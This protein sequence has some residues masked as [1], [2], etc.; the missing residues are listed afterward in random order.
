M[1]RRF[2]GTTY[3]WR[4]IVIYGVFYVILHFIFHMSSYFPGKNPYFV[5]HSTSQVKQKPEYK[6]VEK[7]IE[8]WMFGPDGT[9]DVGTDQNL[10]MFYTKNGDDLG[11]FDDIGYTHFKRDH[12]SSV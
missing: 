12:W 2:A 5:L 9:M 10:G 3:C 1:K 11:M 4:F 7:H 6:T 8:A